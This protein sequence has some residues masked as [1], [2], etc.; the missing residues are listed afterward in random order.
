M[1]KISL[2]KFIEK[3]RGT[4][5][6]TPWGTL[7]GQ[8]V[9]LVQQYIKQCLDQPARARGNARDWATTY[10][11]EGLGYKVSKAQKG[12]LVVYTYKPYGHIAIF[13]DE[14]TVYEQNVRSHDNRCAGYGALWKNYAKVYL[15]PYSSLITNDTSGTSYAGNYPTLPPR[16]YF[17]RGDT[18]S[19][20][21]LLQ[22]FLNWANGDRLVVDGIIGNK[23]IASVKSFQKKVGIEQDG[24]FGKKS[25]EKAKSFKR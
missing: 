22:K 21:K 4:K 9:S 20:V 15:R 3:T 17:R 18:G 19:N 13:I 23:T 24:L 5:Q 16:T 12:D 8:C 2:E 11:R 7:A 6:P 10:V 1:S 14:N 25:L